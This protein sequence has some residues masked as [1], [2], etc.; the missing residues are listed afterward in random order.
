[1]HFTDKKFLKFKKQLYFVVINNVIN[2][3]D[4]LN[5]KLNAAHA[6]LQLTSFLPK[7]KLSK[8]YKNDSFISNHNHVC[9]Q[10]SSLLE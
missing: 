1:M 6:E 10:R 4:V 9:R 5:C 8:F 2:V 7:K 3:E